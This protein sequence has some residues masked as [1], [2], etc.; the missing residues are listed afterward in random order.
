MRT[1][2][3]R[4]EKVMSVNLFVRRAVPMCILS[5]VLFVPNVDAG[6]AR[7]RGVERAIE[8]AERAAAERSREASHNREVTRERAD[9]GDNCRDRPATQEN[10]EK[11]AIKDRGDNDRSA[12]REKPQQASEAQ[13]VLDRNMENAAKA[14]ELLEKEKQDKERQKELRL[15]LGDG[16]SIGVDFP[17]EVN[18]RFPLP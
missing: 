18:I 17:P 4:K 1:D 12:P 13:E 3:P 14:H 7:E 8:R 11:P 6:E 10:S 15:N 9:R 2:S 5:T 16:I